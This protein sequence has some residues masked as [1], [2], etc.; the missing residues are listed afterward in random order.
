MGTN[1]EQFQDYEC[2]HS[3]EYNN[4]KDKQE[5]AKDGI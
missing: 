3:A 4:N 2:V 5:N 1:W